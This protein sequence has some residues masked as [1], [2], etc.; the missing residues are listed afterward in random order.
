MRP[1]ATRAA[2]NVTKKTRPPPLEKLDLHPRNRH[3]GR[4]DFAEL[5]QALPTLKWN[6]RGRTTNTFAEPALSLADR[7]SARLPG[8]K[9][10][11]RRASA[12]AS[13][14]YGQV[15]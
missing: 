6:N 2:H 10:L 4:Y 8:Q 11:E 9:C 14:T 12:G 3:R 13:L 1:K 7:H 15:Q 5:S